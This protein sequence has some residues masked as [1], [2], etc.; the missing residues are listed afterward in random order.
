MDDSIIISV[1]NNIVSLS[2][3][4]LLLS[5]DCHIWLNSTRDTLLGLP[6]WDSAGRLTAPVTRSDRSIAG[7]AGSERLSAAVGFKLSPPPEGWSFFSCAELTG[8][9][10]RA[11]WGRGLAGAIQEGGLVESLLDGGLVEALVDSLILALIEGGLVE[12]LDI[13]VVANFGRGAVVLGTK[14]V[15]HINWTNWMGS[16]SVSY[17]LVGSGSGST[18]GNVDPDKKTSW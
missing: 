13:M 16:I 6:L 18:S 5:S 3:E 10:V 1:N 8:S 12:A 11:L 4:S 17:H 2:L 15:L 7:L 14:K 9:P